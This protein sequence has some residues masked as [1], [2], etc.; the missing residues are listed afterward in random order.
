ME[1]IGRPGDDFRERL[2]RA[3]IE[4]ICNSHGIRNPAKIIP[5]PRGNE[6]VAYHLDDTYFLSFGVNDPTQRKVEVLRILEHIDS[7]PTPKVLDWSPQDPDLHVPY[8]IV[9]RCPGVRLDVLWGKCKQQDRVRLLRSLGSAMGRY[10]TTTLVDAKAAARTVGLDQWV[11]DDSKPTSLSTVESH[12]KQ[13]DSLRHLSDRLK[14]LGLDGSSL[15]ASLEAHYAGD[16]AESDAPFVGPGLIHTEPVAEH[17]IIERTVDTFRLSGCI[18]LEECAIAD[19]FNEIVKMYVTML[20]LDESYLTAFREGYE[21]FFPFPSDAEKRL[22]AG[23]IDSDLS[24]TLW[25]L[26]AMATKPE[27][28]FA[29]HWVAAHMQRLEGWLDVRKRTDRALF[30]KDIGPY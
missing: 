13:Q 16:R 29:T 20:A 6:T 5:E 14:R 11:V 15:T 24:N 25:L 28:S 9:E 26:A 19:S 4:R 3:D 1:R 18:D 12:R 8:M 10:H 22:W 2:S 27:W 17:F 21:Q 7:M 23:A 30:R